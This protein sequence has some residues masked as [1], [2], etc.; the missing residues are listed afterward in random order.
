[1]NHTLKVVSPLKNIAKITPENLVKNITRKLMRE[2]LTKN[3]FEY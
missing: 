2:T 3:E 1:M